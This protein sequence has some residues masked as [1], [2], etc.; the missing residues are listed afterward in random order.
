M[1][2][3][4]LVRASLCLL[5]IPQNAVALGRFKINSTMADSENVNGLTFTPSAEAGIATESH[6]QWSAAAQFRLMAAQSGEQAA[7]FNVTLK[8]SN[9][10][11]KTDSTLISLGRILLR[12][13]STS[14]NE[15]VRSFL[16]SEPS[17]DGI[18]FAR[19]SVETGWSIFAGGPQVAGGVYSREVG[20]TRFA[21][22]YRGERNKI[23]YFP[24]VAS[25]GV[26]IE[27]P[28]ASHTHETEL[29]MKNNNGRFQSEGLIQILVMGPQRTATLKDKS[30]QEFYVG[31]VN[32]NLPKSSHEYRAAAQVKLPLA[33][34]QEQMTS[35][36]FSGASRTAPRSH[37]GTEDEKMFRQG[38]GGESQLVVSLEHDQRQF[39]TQSGLTIEYSS[40]PKYAL[41]AR[42]NSNGAEELYK[43]K[44]QFWTSV[45]FHF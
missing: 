37:D 29:L 2:F 3:R 39:S 28:H 10:S 7:R 5:L 22:T 6:N 1:N 9:L 41:A 19:N 26:I 45:R 4:R 43:L 27:V 31:G 44:S 20:K 17:A 12:A 23:S 16:R 15:A 18:R 25:N 11:Y 13:E 24:E 35:L 40:T 33:E 30:T 36:I 21:F 38:S 8:E 42:K 14:M 34:N 32:T